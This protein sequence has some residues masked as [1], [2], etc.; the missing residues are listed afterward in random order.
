[1]IL[2]IIFIGIFVLGF[3]LHVAD[4]GWDRYGTWPDLCMFVG[5]IFGGTALICWP[6]FYYDSVSSIKQ[7]ESVRRSVMVARERGEEI[8]SA[9]MQLAIIEANAR[10]ADMQ[11]QNSLL[12]LDEFV[13]DKVDD[14]EPIE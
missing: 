9:A 1:M 4:N 5:L 10:L 8:E 7:I 11:Y 13:S 2:L 6:V 12:L 3:L 14:L